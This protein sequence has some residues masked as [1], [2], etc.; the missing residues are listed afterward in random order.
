MLFKT[1]I[2]CLKFIKNKI[3]ERFKNSI[4][5]KEKISLIYILSK[6]VIKIV[7]KYFC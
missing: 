5:F 6:F 3:I 2:I 4:N 1:K 7:F